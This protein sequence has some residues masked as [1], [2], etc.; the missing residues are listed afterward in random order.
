MIEEWIEQCRKGQTR[1]YA[2]VVQAMQPKILGFLYR[3]T[4]NRELA[5]D[6]GQ[7]AFF[8]AFRRLENY[9]SEKSAFSTWLFTI[10]RNLC[11]DELR[12]RRPVQIALEEADFQESFREEN[13]HRTAGDCE[14]E[15]KIMR[16]VDSLD[17][18]FRE[19]FVLHEYED[20][21]LKEIA[22]IIGCPLGTIKSRLHRARLH[23]QKKLAPV[24]CL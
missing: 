7:E 23:L 10:A 12:K 6:L 11:L 9:D 1:A 3:M 20:L 15:Q 22:V 13:P 18:E 8:R 4:Q 5:E 14:L 21:S 2:R 19:I 16:A 24:L 17:E